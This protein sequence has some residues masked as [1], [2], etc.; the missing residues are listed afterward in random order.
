MITI[1]AK[2]TIFNFHI[3]SEVS[4]QGGMVRKVD[5]GWWR[6]QDVV[7][8]C[9][10]SWLIECLKLFSKLIMNF[11]EI[12]KFFMQVHSRTCRWVMLN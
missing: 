11:C 9:R 4:K 6:S 7:V 5:S 3:F 10:H 12:M 2:T 1:Q 8:K